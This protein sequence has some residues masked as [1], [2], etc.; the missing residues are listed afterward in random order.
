[1]LR[2]LTAGQAPRINKM[3]W[4]FFLCLALTCG[5]GLAGCGGSGASSPA[6]QNQPPATPPGPTNP[7]TQNPPSPAPQP[8]PPPVPQPL[9]QA[10]SA[11]GPV[12]IMPLG[13]SNTFGIFVPGAYRIK[14][15]QN[16]TADGINAHFVGS[17]SNGPDSLPSQA[18]EGHS[19][20]TIGNIADAVDGWLKTYNPQIVLLMIGTNNMPAGQD[21]PSAEHQLSALIDQIAKDIPQAHIVV[22]SIPPVTWPPDN[23]NVLQYNAAIPGIVAAKAGQGEHVSFMDMYAAVPISDLASYAHLNA[24]GYDKMADAWYTTLKTLTTAN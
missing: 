24:A 18:N 3:F 5:L 14:L 22:A 10:L 11:Q 23:A 20:W 7:V 6:T 13:D 12:R 19:G 17:L 15:Y 1:M 21:I 16:L 8:A 2:I 9:L 4:S